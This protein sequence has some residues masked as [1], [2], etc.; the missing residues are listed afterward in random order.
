MQNI[1]VNTTSKNI[2]DKRLNLKTAWYVKQL[3]TFSRNILRTYV[4]YE[5]KY[6]GNRQ[7]MRKLQTKL[8]RD[9][10]KYSCYC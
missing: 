3:Q 10:K 8:L 6:D 7:E 2:R 1:K 9:F 4:T 5:G